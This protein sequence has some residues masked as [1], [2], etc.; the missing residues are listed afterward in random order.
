[1]TRTR[2]PMAPAGPSIRFSVPTVR[3]SPTPS[4]RLSHLQYQAA[5]DTRPHAVIGRLPGSYSS[6]PGR[7][8][9]TPPAP[10]RRGPP[11]GRSRA[12]R[13]VRSRRV[14]RRSL[15]H[16]V[17]VDDRLRSE[18]RHRRAPHVLDGG[19]GSYEQQ[20]KVPPDR[21]GLD[22]DVVRQVRGPRRSL[23]S[24]SAPSHARRTNIKL[25]DPLPRGGLCRTATACALP[26]WVPEAAFQ[27]AGVSDWG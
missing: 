18:A 4:S 21:I 20:L 5:L 3:S 19:L 17:D 26:R 9:R 1:M 8:R 12:M 24:P 23:S 25:T 14:H 6:G 22:L 7:T 2:R 27:P 16:H 15:N 13:V 11:R 10:G